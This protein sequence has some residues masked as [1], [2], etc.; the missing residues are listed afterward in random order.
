MQNLQDNYTKKKEYQNK[1]RNGSMKKTIRDRFATELCTQPKNAKFTQDTK[2][3]VSKQGQEW[4][5]E[6]SFI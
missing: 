5:A 3:C 1:D 2:K 4:I 6:E